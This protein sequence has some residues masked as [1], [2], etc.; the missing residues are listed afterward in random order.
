MPLVFSYLL[1]PF[2]LAMSICFYTASLT[3]T[4]ECHYQTI[5]VV[6]NMIDV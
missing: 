5:T 3:K 1:F 6:A 4:V 2:M